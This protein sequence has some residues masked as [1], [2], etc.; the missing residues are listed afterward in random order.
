MQVDNDPKQK[1][2]FVLTAAIGGSEP[3]LPSEQLQ[4]L[5]AA[6]KSH[7]EMSAQS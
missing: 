5:A 4:H 7:K 1:L 2:P 6:V 3:T